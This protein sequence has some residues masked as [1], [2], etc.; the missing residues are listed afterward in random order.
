MVS[1]VI[2]YLTTY[3]LD[4]LKLPAT[5]AFW[6]L[7]VSGLCGVIFQPISGL[8]SDKFGR[9]PV[10]MIPWSLLLLAVLPA[11]TL[12]DQYRSAEVLY[13]A[14]AGLSILTAL[15]A[16]AVIVSLTESLPAR[17]RSGTLAIVY[18]FAISIFGGST[19]FN[20]T[21]L[22]QTTGN[23]LAPA[24]YLVVAVLVGLAAMAATRESAPA[25]TGQK[26]PP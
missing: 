17:V 4:T 23:P 12:M 3:A 13:I 8:L 25:K 7:V 24:W 19:Q 26:A 22:I 1:Y 18:A 16:P 6:T 5:L 11:F 20:V 2:N 21:W 15:S 14:T 10:M 9:K